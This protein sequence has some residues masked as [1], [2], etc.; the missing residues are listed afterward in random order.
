MPFAVPPSITTRKPLSCERV[1]VNW[2]HPLNKGLVAWW[3]ANEENAN[4]IKDLCFGP[5]HLATCSVGAW[6]VGTPLGMMV[7]LTDVT[8]KYFDAG[9][10]ADFHIT[11]GLTLAAD[12]TADDLAETANAGIVA[13]FV[14]TGNQRCYSLLL[15][16]AV[17]PLV[18][19][20][21]VSSLGTSAS[22]VY[23]L[24]T[25]T[26]GSNTFYRTVGVYVPST[27][28]TLYLDG[29]QEAVNITSIPANI[30]DSA[31][32]H[33]WIGAQASA[34][35]R[36][37]GKIGNIQIWNRALTPQEVALYYKNPYGTPDN[38]RLI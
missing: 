6:G 4:S 24:G 32:A 17:S 1:K 29:K 12:F 38:P 35:G 14:T 31:T 11:G 18:I 5:S 10:A 37:N 16:H 33:L 23:V 8:S 7:Q 22:A 36:L 25:T 34:T 20:F 9:L 27:S 13:R 26:I 15:A 21:G 28:L 3:L 30:Y 2:E 19:N